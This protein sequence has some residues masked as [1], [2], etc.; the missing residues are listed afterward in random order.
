MEDKKFIQTELAIDDSSFYTLSD[1]KSRVLVPFGFA[2]T[3]FDG[4]LHEPPQ[5]QSHMDFTSTLRPEQDTVAASVLSQLKSS[6]PAVVMACPPGFGKTITSI[7]VACQLKVKTLIVVNKLLLAH[8]WISALHTFVPSAV[9]QFLK[10]KMPLD[11]RAQFIVVNAVN[12]D[13]FEK[14][15]YDRLQLLIVDELHQIITKKLAINLL[16]I[17][18]RYVLGLSATPYRFDDYHKAIAW[19]FGSQC[20]RKDLLK[21][22]RVKYIETNFVPTIK[23]RLNGKLDW[24]TVLNS[25]AENQPRNQLIVD[26]VIQYPSRTWLILVKRVHHARLLQK[27]FADKNIAVETLVQ[28]QLSF[29]KTVKILIGTTNKLG[30]GFDHAAIDSL[31]IAADVKNYFVQFLGRCMRRPDCVPLVID[32]VDNFFSSR[33][34]FDERLKVYVHHGGVVEHPSSSSSSRLL[35]STS[36]S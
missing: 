9:V 21:S 35:T 13:K 6:E 25:Q 34:H 7:L 36:S 11:P 24:N 32:M 19:F 29:D 18:P 3:L 30:V 33:K 28:H 22:H 23:T 14:G 2:H 31:F 15:T 27:M 12:I 16:R 17:T 10:P 26:T 8:Q 4:L 5:L 1:D 20:L